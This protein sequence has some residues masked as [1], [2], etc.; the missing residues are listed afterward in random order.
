MN[1]DA[2]INVARALNESATDGKKNIVMLGSAK[3]PAFL[4]EYGTRKIE[5]ENFMFNECPNLVAFTLRPGVI[6]NA[7]HRN[8]SV[9]VAKIVDLVAAANEKVV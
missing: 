3:P 6:W 8:W 4:P 9:P 7:E 5:A 2:C 1:R